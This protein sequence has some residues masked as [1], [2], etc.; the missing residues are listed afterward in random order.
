MKK[1]NTKRTVRAGIIIGLMNIL[2]ACSDKEDTINKG[3]EAAVEFCDCY[4]DNT[5]ETCLKELKD[6]YQA[7]EHMSEEF[8]DAF[9]QTSTCG[10]ELVIEQSKSAV[11][12]TV[13]RLSIAN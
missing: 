1:V 8:I 3:N 4:K 9:N 11:L 7:Y 2:I 5:K 12:G 13:H 10:I 6:K